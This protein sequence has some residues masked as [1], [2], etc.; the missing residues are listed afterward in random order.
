M[1][2]HLETGPP[3]LKPAA[4]PAQSAAQP[5]AKTLIDAT[6]RT[7]AQLPVASQTSA[8]PTAAFSFG[9]FASAP[10]VFAPSAEAPVKEVRNQ[11]QTKPVNLPAAPPVAAPT[12][13]TVEQPPIST[14]PTEVPAAQQPIPPPAVA[15]PP[16]APVPL[17]EAPVIEKDGK[18]T[19]SI[20]TAAIVN[21]EPFGVL[22]SSQLSAGAA[23]RTTYST[24][25][26]IV[27]KQPIASAATASAPPVAPAQ[28]TTAPLT[29]RQPLASSN[30]APSPPTSDSS[31]KP[32]SAPVPSTEAAAKG[33]REQTTTSI[34]WADAFHFGGPAELTA[35]Q[36]PPFVPFVFPPPVAEAS[37]ASAAALQASISAQQT[38][39]A[40]LIASRQLINATSALSTAEQP[41]TPAPVA[42]PPVPSSAGAT[43]G[44]QPPKRPPVVYGANHLWTDESEEEDEAEIRRAVAE[45]KE[46]PARRQRDAQEN[47]RE[48]PQDE[49]DTNSPHMNLLG[50]PLPLPPNGPPA[51]PKQPGVYSSRGHGLPKLPVLPPM[52]AP[53]MPGFPTLQPGSFSSILPP[54]MAAAQPP[55]YPQY[56]PPGFPTPYFNDFAFP[57]QP[58]R[59]MPPPPQ[60]G[61]PAG[62][63]S[64]LGMPKIRAMWTEE[65]RRQQAAVSTIP[66]QKTKETRAKKTAEQKLQRAKKPPT[67]QP[68]EHKKTAVEETVARAYAQGDLLFERHQQL[69]NELQQQAEESTAGRTAQPAV[70]ETNEAPVLPPSNEQQQQSQVDVPTAQVEPEPKES[71]RSV[72]RLKRGQDFLMH[73]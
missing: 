71:E 2:R 47:R 5:T 8:T 31:S 68:A 17:H 36:P 49:R 40:A 28:A 24:S 51:A 13:S 15:P 55:G 56:A 60:M 23:D 45:R 16:A 46:R 11:V 27:A 4:L 34:P 3:S 63:Y 52:P 67:A 44:P 62:G 48:Q 12:A 18:A 58:M 1:K 37:A 43:A 53:Q 41:L 10:F 6:A 69:R 9:P 66:A 61:G 73:L 32:P 21:R 42:Q 14:P 35:N 33:P 70:Q 59:P 26:T 29:A 20:S 19:I 7:A 65:D 72:A 57:P 39:I 54:P 25:K 50:E 64:N 22:P 38:S 30:V